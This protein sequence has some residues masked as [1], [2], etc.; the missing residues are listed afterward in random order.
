MRRDTKRKWYQNR[1]I[2]AAL[3]S[4]VALLLVPVVERLI[5]VS[6]MRPHAAPNASTMPEQEKPLVKDTQNLPV[7]AGEE[8]GVADQPQNDSPIKKKE[9]PIQP[10]ETKGEVNEPEM[11]E[12]LKKSETVIT[13]DETEG[14]VRKTK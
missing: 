12:L 11:T 14:E 10:A 8:V 6:D 5:K 4:A 1:V 7:E 2:Q 9:P 3:I 13:P